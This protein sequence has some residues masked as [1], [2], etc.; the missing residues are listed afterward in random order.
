MIKVI[1]LQS[2]QYSNVAKM[3]LVE[4]QFKKSSLVV[5]L[6]HRLHLLYFPVYFEIKYEHKLHT[7]ELTKN[8]R[9]HQVQRH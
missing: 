5:S 8:I 9:T 2:G 6:T 4:F 1:I 3:C 7:G